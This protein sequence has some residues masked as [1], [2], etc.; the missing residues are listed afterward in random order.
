[1]IWEEGRVFEFRLKLF[2]IL[3]FGVHKIKVLCFDPVSYTIFTNESNAHVPVWNHRI[4][5]K[6]IDE[7]TTEY[8]DEVEICAGWYIFG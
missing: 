6:K 3:S 5:L 1:M 4:S 2:G 8:T 7:N